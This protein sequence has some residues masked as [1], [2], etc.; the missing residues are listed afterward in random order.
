MT[1][2]SLF[3]G[4]GGFD[5]AAERVGWEVKWQVEI[6]E[7]KRAVLSA[8]FPQARQ[9]A[10]VREVSG[11]DLAAVDVLTAGFPCQ[12]ISPAGRRAGITGH[13][14]GLWSE[15]ARIAGRLR[16]APRYVLLE[17]SVGLLKRGLDRVLVDLAGL[18]FDAEWTVLP[19]AVLGSPQ[20][21]ARLW[22][23]AYPCGE[24]IAA[25]DTV[26]ARWSEPHGCSW[27]QAE[28]ALGRV[29]DGV[30]GWMVGALGDAVVP[31]VA[32]WI[33][34]RIQEAEGVAA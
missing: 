3:A 31:Q 15:V 33:F 24:R 1:V 11:A 34:R 19:A 18:G 32:E 2:G 9:F 22:I 27:W 8:R 29:A 16:P 14:S 25:D 30:P 6:D 10:D 7:R 12:D 23:L 4:I 28:P 26:C 20:L 5:L 13:K 21:R 17:N